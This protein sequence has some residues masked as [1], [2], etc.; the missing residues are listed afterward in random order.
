MKK[1]VYKLPEKRMSRD[2]LESR[3]MRRAVY[4]KKRQ[5]EK[6]AFECG[7]DFEAIISVTI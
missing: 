3:L 7:F 6:I 2:E 5:L 1:T 4:R